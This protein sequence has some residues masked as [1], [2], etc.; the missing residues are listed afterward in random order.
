MAP[1]LLIINH[2]RAAQVANGA[3]YAIAIQLS[4]ISE[5][6]NGRHRRQEIYLAEGRRCVRDRHKLE[7]VRGR[8]QNGLLQRLLFASCLLVGPLE[9]TGGARRTLVGR[10]INL[11]SHCVRTSNLSY[12]GSIISLSSNLG[13]AHNK[14]SQNNDQ[15][16]DYATRTSS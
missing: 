14:R 9:L 4:L 5:A 1:K 10:K 16:A 12:S 15:L 3:L 13:L 11:D 6:Q 7:A 2:N 8:G